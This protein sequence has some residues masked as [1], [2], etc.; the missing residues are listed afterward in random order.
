MERFDDTRIA[1]IKISANRLTYIFTIL[2]KTT[3]QIC[4]NCTKID[5]IFCAKRRFLIKYL[6]KRGVFYTY[7]IC[8]QKN[9][10]ERETED[11]YDTWCA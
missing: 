5:L 7:F 4:E 2:P 11:H 1:R 3:H 8:N 9:I 10:V 6:D